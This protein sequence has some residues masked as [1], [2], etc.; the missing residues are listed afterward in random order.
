[1]ALVLGWLSLVTFVVSVG[2]AGAYIAAAAT[3]ILGSFAL[4]T[5]LTWSRFRLRRVA[6]DRIYGSSTL[7][8]GRDGEQPVEGLF[9]IT[10]HSINW[11]SLLKRDLSIPPVSLALSDVVAVNTMYLGWPRR[12]GIEVVTR[13]GQ[14]LRLVASADQRTVARS[15]ANLGVPGEHAK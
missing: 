4:V 9:W 5:A 13:S 14:P 12:V 7:R 15:L 11:T 1:V 3:L 8:L 2:T 10:P 6:S